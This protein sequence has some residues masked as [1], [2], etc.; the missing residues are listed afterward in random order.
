MNPSGIAQT[1]CST[2]SPARP[3]REKWSPRMWEG[4]DFLAWVRLLTRNRFAVEFPYW[5]IAGFIT[6]MSF[7]HMV[8]RWIQHGLYGD[9][10]DQTRIREQ[11]IFVI[12]HWR[13]G[14]TLLHELLILDERFTYP[15]TYACMEPNHTLLTEAFVKRYMGW[16]MPDRRPMDR[17]AAGWSRPQEDEFALCMLGLPSTYTDFAFPNRPTIYP[18][19]L[20][21]SGL[22]P[23]Q[24]SRWKREFLRFLQ[25]LTFRDPR[26]LVLKSPPHTARIPAL[27]ELF[28]DARFV[29]IVRDPYVVFP[30]TVNLW[31]SLGRKHGLQTPRNEVA[32]REKVF[33]EFRVIYDRL[34]EARGLIRPGRF[35]ELHYETLIKDPLG[36]MEAVY[37]TLEL[38]GFAAYRPRLE[39]YLRQNAGYETNKY[40]LSREDREEVTQRWGDVIKRYGYAEPSPTNDRLS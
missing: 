38:D 20:D 36:Q 29:H 11:P 35:H 27:L 15:N 14:T 32:I 8:M 22:N 26:R 10:I 4:L 39:D 16:A 33:Q 28:P 2:P 30:S 5:Y 18:G 6:G 24:R 19:A 23:S 21:L 1:S 25:M 12:G 31:K 17:M 40:Q 7:T 34:E 37:E 9:R 13:T 3:V